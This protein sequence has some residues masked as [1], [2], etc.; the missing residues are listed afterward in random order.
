MIA[1]VNW[2]L[3]GA[4]AVAALF[5]ID[6]LLLYFEERGWIFYRRNKPNFQNAASVL[7][8]VHALFEPKMTYVIEQKQ[9]EEQQEDEDDEGD[10]PK[11]GREDP[12]RAR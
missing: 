12:R 8:E 6:R 1:I 9:Q 5:L 3:I 11:P 2:A 10:R 7:I 4:G